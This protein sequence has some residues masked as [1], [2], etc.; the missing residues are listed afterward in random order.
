MAVIVSMLAIEVT[1]VYLVD[2]APAVVI[3]GLVVWSSVVLHVWS[4]SSQIT[5][6]TV[7]ATDSTAS[8]EERDA[9]VDRIHDLLES[10]FGVLHATVEVEHRGRDRHR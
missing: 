1:G 9:L 6:A 2:P 7:F 5:V 4:L 10:E 3:A 8:L